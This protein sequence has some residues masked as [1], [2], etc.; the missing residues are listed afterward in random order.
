M[1]EKKELNI[2]FDWLHNHRPEEEIYQKLIIHKKD[3]QKNINQQNDQGNTLLML[4]VARRYNKNAI[5]LLN[6][7]ANPNI[8]NYSN[9]HPLHWVFMD[10][11][12]EIFYELEK[13]GKMPLIHDVIKNIKNEK[14]L[15]LYLNHLTFEEL[16]SLKD[17]YYEYKTETKRGM[18][19]FLDS[20][21]IEKNIQ[22]FYLEKEMKK[23][24]NN[25][26]NNNFKKI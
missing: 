5:F 20:I 8:V 26:L 23:I 21:D 11:N 14:L 24:L 25:N 9:S 7:G 22:I 13:K 3:I 6:L 17:F 12:F 10:S 1:K 4:N 19:F 16:M 2:I 18:K 15:R